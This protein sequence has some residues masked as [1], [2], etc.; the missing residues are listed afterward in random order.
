MPVLQVA[1]G[2]HGAE[3]GLPAEVGRPW[4]NN[5]LVNIS[6]PFFFCLCISWSFKHHLVRTHTFWNI[7]SSS[8][9]MLIH[10]ACQSLR[11]IWIIDAGSEMESQAE[12]LETGNV[13]CLDPQELMNTVILTHKEKRVDNIPGQRL[14]SRLLSLFS[15]DNVLSKPAPMWVAMVVEGEVLTEH[16]RRRFSH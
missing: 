12:P 7:L 13:V 15:L 3:S 8:V 16:A 4:V 6:P 5:V 11:L 9:S 10:R 1:S 2:T 14:S